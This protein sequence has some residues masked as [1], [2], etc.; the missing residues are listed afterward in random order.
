M[1][2]GPGQAADVRVASVATSTLPAPTPVTIESVLGTATPTILLRAARDVG[3][4]AF[5]T[6]PDILV[7]L[8]ASIE[9]RL[10]E[11]EMEP[12]FRQI[13]IQRT[14]DA[15]VLRLPMAS[16]LLRIA[17]SPRGWLVTTAAAQ[18]AIAGIVPQ[19]IEDGPDRA[20]LRQHYP[21][22]RRAAERRRPTRNTNVT[23]VQHSERYGI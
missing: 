14:Q 12:M 21:V 1:A 22:L 19:L 23:P 17:R 10:P 8:D 20:S 11:A 2:G 3:A 7:V 5:R 13:T 9:Y 6:G 16:D 15:T 18:E 4:A